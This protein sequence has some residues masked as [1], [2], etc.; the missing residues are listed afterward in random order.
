MLNHVKWVKEYLPNADIR[1]FTDSAW[2]VNFHDNFFQ[3]LTTFFANASGGAN[4]LEQSK[5]SLYVALRHHE[6]CDSVEY[7]P[8]CCLLLYCLIKNRSY[9]PSDI[10]VLSA[11]SMI[12]IC[13]LPL[14]LVLTCTMYPRFHLTSTL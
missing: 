14:F 10:P 5:K 7:G 11:F 2:F 12:F 9:I 6:P 13:W 1:V 3:A 8:P 4:I